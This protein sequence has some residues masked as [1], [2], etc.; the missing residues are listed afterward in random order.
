[1]PDRSDFPG[2]YAGFWHRVL[3]WLIDI[4]VLALCV[5]VLGVIGSP[6]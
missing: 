4:L 1:M 2:L 5:T 6:S 3:A